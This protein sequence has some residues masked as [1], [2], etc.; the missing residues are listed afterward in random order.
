MGKNSMPRMLQDATDHYGNANNEKKIIFYA[1]I[2][3]G[4]TTVE[5]DALTAFNGMVV[6][7]TT[8]DRFDRYQGDAWVGGE[9]AQGAHIADVAA[10]TTTD[11]SDAPA[12]ADALR[13]DLV[14]T[15]LPAIATG[16]NANVTKINAILAALEAHGIVA[17]S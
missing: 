15:T 10:Y 16:I 8:T 4:V 13:D 5:R 6:Y 17:T 1:L 9:A 7:N 14:A 12:D 11:P 2:H 3:D